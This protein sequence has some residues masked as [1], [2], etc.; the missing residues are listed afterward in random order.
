MLVAIMLLVAS[1]ATGTSS[2]NGEVFL[3][4]KG[5]AYKVKTPAWV[6]SAIEGGAREVETMAEYRDFII[7]IAQFEDQSLQGAQLVAEKMDAQTE[8]ASYLSLRVKDAFK[9]ARL[10]DAESKL[11][12]VFGESF[13]ASVAEATYSGFRKDTDWWIKVQT[14]A[15]GN[16][17]ERQFYRIFQLWTIPKSMLNEQFAMLSASLQADLPPTAENKKAVDLVQGIVAKEF[18]EEK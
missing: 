14:S 15:S 18:F 17:P 6:D 13:L 7:F 4:D 9:G 8:L 12:G 2:M 1:C 10:T 3:E 11:L 16:K 5:T